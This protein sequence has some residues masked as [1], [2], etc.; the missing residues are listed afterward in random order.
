MPAK[1]TAAK[2]DR[3][4]HNGR[5]ADQPIASYPA[6]EPLATPSY[7]EDE[8][9]R[10]VTEAIN[11]LVADAIALWT[12]TKN[13]HWHLSGSHFRDYHLLFDTH[14]EKILGSVDVLAERV[15]RVGGLTIRS[16]SHVAQLAKIEDD[17]RDF[18]PPAEMIRIL[19]EDN[20]GMAR[21]QHAAAKVC[22]D[23]GDNVT[24]DLLHQVID[25]TQRRVWFLYEI[26]RGAGNAD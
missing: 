12:K 19:L 13:F 22:E 5:V 23:N 10:A 16:I 20:R 15:R 9:V 18:V 6:P 7:L 11:P 4:T 21:R 17:N 24:A 3:A 25:D 26:S 1:T 2:P 8:Q 14:A